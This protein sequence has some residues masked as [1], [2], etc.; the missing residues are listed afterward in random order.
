MVSRKN[1]FSAIALMGFVLW[2]PVCFAE[3]QNTGIQVNDIVVQQEIVKPQEQPTAQIVTQDLAQFEPTAPIAAIDT[4]PEVTQV[5]ELVPVVEVQ[6]VVPQVQNDDDGKFNGDT[7]LVNKIF[8]TLSI[9]GAANLDEVV[10][11]HDAE[12]F[13]SFD[14]IN[15][16]FNTLRIHGSADIKNA[17]LAG[18]CEI[19]GST[20]IKKATINGD[21]TL[22]GAATISKA[23]AQKIILNA[24]KMTLTETTASSLFICKL[25]KG[26]GRQVIRI[27]GGVITGDV[28]FEGGNGHVVLKKG[29]EIKGTVTGGVVVKQ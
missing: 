25:T 16:S 1:F 9:L 18:N 6:E 20:K 15:S 23:T 27:N 5:Q 3:D 24:L 19:T 7:V 21:L 8:K 26:K 4:I 10:V 28:V 2:A 13:G 22:N 17:I 29:A 12:V 14:S 11:A